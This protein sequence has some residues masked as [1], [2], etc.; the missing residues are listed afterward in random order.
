MILGLQ[1]GGILIIE[2]KTFFLIAFTASGDVEENS[3]C[4]FRN[5]AIFP[6]LENPFHKH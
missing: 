1:L 4:C 3:F 2:T 5:S 6:V